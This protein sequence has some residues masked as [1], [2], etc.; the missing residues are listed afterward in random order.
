MSTTNRQLVAANQELG[1]A[2][3]ELQRVNDEVLL[4]Q[5]QEQASAEEIRTLNEELQASNEE[6]E[7]VNE[8]LEATVEELHNSND[9]LAERTREAQEL[10]STAQQ[11]RQASEAEQARLAAILLSLGDAVLV[12]DPTGT[13]L[14]ANTAY[15]RLFGDASSPIAALDAAGEP[16]AACRIRRSSARPGVR[17]SSWSS[18]WTGKMVSVATSRRPDSQSRA[19][20]T[21]CWV[22]L[23][24]YGTSPSAASTDFRT[25]FWPW[26]AMSC[27]RR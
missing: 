17:P 27:E 21:P 15:T 14:L 18:L 25:S 9:D 12:V 23:S 6:L 1:R 16:S 11:Q 19:R 7:T 8:E 5:E 4:A 22:G 24:P 26:P 13:P 3:L 20:A 10:A 2:N